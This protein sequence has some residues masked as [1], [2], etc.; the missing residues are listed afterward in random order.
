MVYRRKLEPL[1]ALVAKL[2][3]A[4]AAQTRT[5]RITLRGL[6]RIYE[7]QAAIAYKG[8]RDHVS[9]DLIAAE[10]FRRAGRA[11]QAVIDNCLFL[12]LDGIRTFFEL[13][14]DLLAVA[15]AAEQAILDAA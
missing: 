1:S 13:H 7:L 6:R 12:S 11:Y 3:E 5:E 9:S 14:G 15:D 10:G 8:A 2:R 4:R